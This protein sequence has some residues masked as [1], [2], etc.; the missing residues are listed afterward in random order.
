MDPS[1]IRKPIKSDL[2][3]GYTFKVICDSELGALAY[4][5]IYSGELRK[6]SNLLNSSRGV[7]E[8]GKE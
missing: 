5:R 6:N 8:K 2:F 4:T 7:V 1:L 3:T